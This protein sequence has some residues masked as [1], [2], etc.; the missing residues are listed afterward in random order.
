MILGDVAKMGAGLL[1]GKKK[2]V[3]GK[4]V[5]AK[6]VGKKDPVYRQKANPN[7]TNSELDAKKI[8]PASNIGQSTKVEKATTP[9]KAAVQINSKLIEVRTLLKGS[10]VLEKMQ[11]KDKKGTREKLKRTGLEEK[12]E[13]DASKGQFGLKIPGVAKIG[14]FWDRI[15]NFFINVLWAWIAIKMVDFLPALGRILPVIASVVEWVMDLGIGFIDVLGTAVNAGYAAYDWT[16]GV[17]GNVFGE[18]GLQT[19]DKISGVMNTMLNSTMALGLAMVALS[20]EFGSSVG[21]WIKGTRSIFKHGLKRSG[22]RLLLKLFGKKT[23]STLLGKG[24]A[25]KGAVTAGTAKGAGLLGGIKAT[26]GTVVGGGL[27]FASKAN[28]IMLTGFLSSLLGE[29]GFQ[30]KKIAQDQEEKSYKKFKEKKW[31]QPMKYFWGAKHLSDKFSSYLYGGIGTL[32][33]IIGTPFRYLGELIK[34][35]F[36]DK[37]GKEKQRTNMAKFDARIREQFREIVNAFSLGML[38][39]E[40]GAFGSLFG[41]RGTDAMGYTQ[42]QSEDKKNKKNKWTSESGKLRP[43]DHDY[44]SEFED[45]LGGPIDFG[46]MG[47][48]SLISKNQTSGAQSVID[49]IAKRTSYEK[50]GGGDPLII[51]VPIPSPEGDPEIKQKVVPVP[52]GNIALSDASGWDI[53][54]K[55][56]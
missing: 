8:I 11:E 25:T 47:S 37:A 20:N 22:K 40:K 55:G 50:M 49:S 24:L 48:S 7:A 52:I 51:P 4:Q 43:E 56:S 2:K 54:Y 28:P 9:E 16:R 23:A 39:K 38:A 6:I 44:A 27:K 12:A 17:I 15:K 30:L 29:G 18:K 36:L 3:S 41:K 19:F 14:S 5:A 33:D 32:L 53:L 42:S 31:F 26:A 10:L 1:K 21:D 35:P 46:S 34:Y 13:K 45:I